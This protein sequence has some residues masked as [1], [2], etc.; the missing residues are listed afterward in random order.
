MT[1]PT[2]ITFDWGGV[3]LRICRSFDEGVQAAGLDPREPVNDPALYE[4]RR[5]VSKQYQI[6]AIGEGE[7]FR[8]TSRA[9]DGL[10]S[11]DE[12][13]LIHDAWLLGEYDGTADLMDELNAIDGIDTAILSNT[14]A[15]HW[16]RRERD[17]PTAGRAG[18]Q[19]ASHLLRAAKPD[20]DIYHAFAEATG[21]TGR[22][23]EIMFFDDLPENIETARSL[24]WRGVLIDHTADTAAQ[25]RAALCDAGVLA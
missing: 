25:M 8:E 2:L 5:G 1:P 10:Y 12:I 9:I 15:R 14:N 24:G 22:E 20:T 17:F 7:F 6:G 16:A 13:A 11:P 4:I 18:Q 21:Y 19:H 23:R 3:L